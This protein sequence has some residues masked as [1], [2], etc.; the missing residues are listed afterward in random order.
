M[1]EKFLDYVGTKGKS[2]SWSNGCYTFLIELKPLN[3]W[4]ML[5]LGGG[6]N[7]KVRVDVDQYTFVNACAYTIDW[8]KDKIIDYRY[9]WTS[10]SKIINDNTPFFAI[11]DS[12]SMKCDPRDWW[13]DEKYIKIFNILCG[14]LSDTYIWEMALNCGVIEEIENVRE[15]EKLLQLK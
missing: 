15:S 4:E 13:Y 12:S 11:G 9:E 6:K 10:F 8:T 3:D 2:Y 7:H 1:K 5:T 14:L